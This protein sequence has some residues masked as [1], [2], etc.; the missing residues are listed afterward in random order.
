[1]PLQSSLHDRADFVSNIN[2]YII[3]KWFIIIRNYLSFIIYRRTYKFTDCTFYGLDLGIQ[4][5]LTTNAVP[6]KGIASLE[7]T[8]HGANVPNVWG[9]TLEV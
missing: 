9:S 5:S 7:L 2:K 1:M 3:I 8:E 6:D 4:C